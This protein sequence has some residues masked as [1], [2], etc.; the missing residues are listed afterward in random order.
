MPLATP[1]A[2]DD[3]STNHSSSHAR[4][5]IAF[6]QQESSRISNSRTPTLIGT[7]PVMRKLFSV[8]ERVAPSDAS[9]LVTGATG[10]GKE[11]AARA[12][13]ELSS[14][15]DG[16]FVDINCSAIPETLIE[17][18]LFGHQRGTFTGAHEN[19]SGL[20]E[21][22]SGGTL[23]LDE[24]DALNL[25][26]QA[27]LLRVL[28]ERTVRRIGA[29]ANIAIDVR[30]ISAT[31][32]DLAQAVAE[33]RFRPDL[34]YRLRVLPLHVPELCMRGGDV[35]LLVDHFLRIKSE[36]NGQPL[37]RFTDEAMRALCEYPWPGNVRELENTIEYALAI[38][39]NDELGIA[40][41]PPEILTAQ[42]QPSA[43]DF[44]QVLQAYMNDMVPLAEIEKRYI[45]SVLQQFGG[46]QVRAAAAL[47]IDRSKLY[48]RLKQYG[49]MAVRFLQ[50]EDLD[51]HQLRSH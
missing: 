41:L 45:L 50:E 47:G 22:A 11:L 26:A 37:R 3:W 44:R 31:N 1:T 19:R 20:F 42:P 24:V 25:S 27:K 13:H 46:N 8:I 32:C 9:V 5:A 48:R 51:G 43:D 21:K 30:I 34:Y 18:E 15:R 40:D 39:L 17:A 14:R 49:V 7:S 38:G 4:S 28:Q 10:T 16:P 33:G 36:R 2:I 35:Q 6:D 12:I 23:F 29:R